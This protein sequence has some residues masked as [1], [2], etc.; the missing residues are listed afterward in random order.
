MYLKNDRVYSG[1]W[2]MLYCHFCFFFIHWIIEYEDV[3]WL[4]ITPALRPQQIDFLARPTLSR[5]IAAT[6]FRTKSVDILNDSN[7][8]VDMSLEFFLVCKALHN[9]QHAAYIHIYGIWNDGKYIAT[10]DTNFESK[11]FL[12]LTWGY[13]IVNA[14]EQFFLP[15]VQS[16]SARSSMQKRKHIII[17][18][19]EE[20]KKITPQIHLHWSQRKREKKLNIQKILCA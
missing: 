11:L 8:A 13:C 7:F 16:Y 6:F 9:M 18:N 15:S 10:Y 2:T 17:E 4:E 14:V 3:L 12:K 5:F 20:E 19:G 1:S